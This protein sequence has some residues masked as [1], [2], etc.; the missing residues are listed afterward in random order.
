MGGFTGPG[1]RGGGPSGPSQMPMGPAR[2][3]GLGVRNGVNNRGGRGGGPAVGNRGGGVMGGRGGGG[4][5]GSSRGRIA[6][7]PNVY[8]GGGGRGGGGGNALRGHGSKGNFSGGNKDFQNRRGG[9]SFNAG[10]GGGGG[11]GGSYSQPGSFRGRGGPPG[12]G[13]ITGPRAMYPIP[14]KALARDGS[15]SSSFGSGG[16]GGKKDE[17]RRT[18]TDFKI[19]GLEIRELSW[20]WG[21]VP[22]KVIKVEA[23]EDVLES[24]EPSQEA[25]KEENV[26]EESLSN[27]PAPSAVDGAPSDGDVA[28]PAAAS[29]NAKTEDDPPAVAAVAAPSNPAPT[30]ALPPS[31]IRIYFHTPVTVEDSRPPTHPSLAVVPSDSRKGK[32]KKLEDDEDVEEGRGG[33]PPAPHQADDRSSVAASVAETE[34]ESDWLMAAI[35]ED[36][37]ADGEFDAEADD[38]EDGEQLHVSQIVKPTDNDGTTDGGDDHEQDGESNYIVR[39]GAIWCEMILLCGR[40]DRGGCFVRTLLTF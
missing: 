7:K 8:D 13:H 17:N 23:M 39:S 11:G 2:G 40:R 20:T 33:P 36:E 4:V 28:E 1:G 3:G 35:A 34:V 12:P 5:G 19:I 6:M 29:Q 30:P 21:T 24:V 9:G 37:E 14:E 38:E 32:R 26:D 27:P 16:G 22:E 25:V 10:V 15:M 31:R 18:L